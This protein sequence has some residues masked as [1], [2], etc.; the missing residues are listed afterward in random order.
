MFHIICYS[1]LPDKVEQLR[2]QKHLDDRPADSGYKSVDYCSI[3]IAAKVFEPN[4][5][6]KKQN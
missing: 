2:P 5:R 6:I 3:G 4:D 1:R